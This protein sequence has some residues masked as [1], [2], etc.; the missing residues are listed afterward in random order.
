MSWHLS[1]RCREIVRL[2]SLCSDGILVPITTNNIWLATH[3][4]VAYPESSVF[5][6]GNI[7]S[8]ETNN[9][10]NMTAIFQDFDK[11]NDDI[12]G[13]A[14]AKVTHMSQSTHFIL[15]LYFV[16]YFAIFILCRLSLQC[17]MG[18][19]LSMETSPSGTSLASLT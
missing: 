9:V 19:L 8:W 16:F 5:T 6:F 12:S 7:S 4:W 11:F 1:V 10:T 3:S 14:V 2:L 13:W 18:Q 15:R 17:F